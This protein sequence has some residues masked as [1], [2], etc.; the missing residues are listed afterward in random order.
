MIRPAS[1]NSISA[2]C[3]AGAR[4]VSRVRLWGLALLASLLV[5]CGKAEPVRIGFIGNVSG[6]G[7]DLGIGG[8]NGAELAV[9]VRN[10][11]GG[12]AGRPVELVAVDDGGDPEHARQ[13]L[14]ELAA[15]GVV[16]VIGPMLSSIAV[17]L[18]PDADAARLPLV[19]PTVT[20]NALAGKDD[21]F[22]RV[23]SPTRDF[24]AISAEHLRINLD[25]KTLAVV[26]DARNAA[27]ANSWLTDFRRPFES[28]GGII[29]NVLTFES[30]D[31][32]GLAP[33]ARA[34]LAEQTDAI[35]ML[36]NS[37]DAAL[38]AQQIRKHD[39]RTLLATSEW[40]A[41]ERLTEIG[42]RAVDG[43]SVPTFVDQDSDAAAFIE[44]RDRYARRFG[45]LPG[46]SGLTGYDAA[47]VILDA[48]AAR[49]DGTPLR[50]YLKSHP[51]VNGLQGR[52]RFDAFGD[53]TRPTF[54]SVV[55]G[56][57]L[58]RFRNYR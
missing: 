15:Q 40:A 45:N 24:A 26:Y 55:E 29:R 56:G 5:A 32:D 41:T 52:F 35:L 31:S 51:E 38:I 44:F 22:F 42:G 8:R 7:A 53:G 16:A 48:L 10:A 34:L 57:R 6:R 1:P 33:L 43:M 37:L 25:V 58:T 54:I 11:S 9:E 14:R 50:D 3:P 28:S 46:F 17:V 18:A 23:I 47:T 20:T 19:S 2:R 30:S 49:P 12:V 36:A 4:Q 13:A 39:Q 27:Y 21:Y